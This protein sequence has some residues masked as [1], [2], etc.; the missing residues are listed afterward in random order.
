MNFTRFYLQILTK[1]C[2]GIIIGQ[3]GAVELQ[4]GE[5]VSKRWGTWI[6]NYASSHNMQANGEEVE[7]IRKSLTENL[8]HESFFKA[9]AG[10]LNDY[11]DDVIFGVAVVDAQTPSGGKWTGE[12]YEEA[13]KSTARWL[14]KEVK[15]QTIFARFCPWK[16]AKQYR[17]LLNACSRVHS[18]AHL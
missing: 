12:D 7:A 1:G 10:F 11:Y 9:K 2:F 6:T 4:R 15:R 16:N 17:E 14:E 18:E 3:M 5:A 13:V 8:L